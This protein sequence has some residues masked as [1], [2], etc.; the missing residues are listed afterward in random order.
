MARVPS[1]SGEARGQGPSSRAGLK[2]ARHQGAKYKE[3]L[4]SVV[5]A[6]ALQGVL[7][8]SVPWVL[9][10]FIL[11]PALGSPASPPPVGIL[12]ERG[13]WGLSPHPQ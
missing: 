12:L 10:C 1:A 6:P 2:Q 8:D 3:T 13:L 7:F 9:T 11:V 4:V 5:L